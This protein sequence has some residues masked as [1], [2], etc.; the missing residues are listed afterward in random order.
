MR[1][2]KIDRKNLT[3]GE[4]VRG[5]DMYTLYEITGM[6]LDSLVRKQ[7]K[8]G[9]GVYRV[10]KTTAKTVRLGIKFHDDKKFFAICN[11]LW[12]TD[13]KKVKEFG[14]AR[15]LFYLF[16]N[17]GLALGAILFAVLTA[18]SG[19]FI[20][21]FTY[22]GSGAV[23]E[24]EVSEYLAAR[25][26]TVFSRF[27]ELDFKALSADILADNPRLTFVRCEKSGN[28]LIVK[29]ALKENGEGVISPAPLPLIACAD[30]VLEELRVY[31]GT[32]VKTVGEEVKAGDILVAPYAE[33]KEQRVETSVLA[34]A[35]IKTKFVYE[36][37]SESDSEEELA[38]LFAE[39][40]LGE[41]AAES[42]VEK[43]AAEDKIIYKITLY[44]KR[45][46]YS[47]NTEVKNP[48]D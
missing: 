5:W 48:K 36:Y 11:D 10:K 39:N 37:V 42:V 8:N 19:D 6:N 13:I 29:L 34:Y 27:S 35:A 21:G 40:A 20:F 2:D 16:R 1:N 15:P 43:F 33:I 38:V 47:G 22:Q 18:L 30:G 25:G 4:Y 28:R 24:R 32:A 44:Y 17:F 14:K 31:R 7:K 45:I 23:C 26:V 3:R 41:R 46:L 9:V 12:Y